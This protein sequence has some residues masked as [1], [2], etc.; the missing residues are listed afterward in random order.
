MLLLLELLL[1][2]QV[3]LLPLQRQEFLPPQRLL[4]PGGDSLWPAA[5]LQQRHGADPARLQ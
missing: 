5:V 1:E 4:L 2:L 3:L